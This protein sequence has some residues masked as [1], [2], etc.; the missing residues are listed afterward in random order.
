MRTAQPDERDFEIDCTLRANPAVDVKSVLWVIGN[1]GINLTVGESKEGYTANATVSINTKKALYCQPV[2]GG[3]EFIHFISYIS[4]HQ[5]SNLPLIS[6]LLIRPTFH[7]YINPNHLYNLPSPISI[8]I[9]YTTFH[10]YI[11]PNHSP[12]LSPLYQSQPFIQP[13]T[14]YQSQPFIQP[15][16]PISIPTFHP[17]LHPYINPNDSSNLSPHINHNHSSNLPPYINHNH[18]SI[19]P[20]YINPSN[21]LNRPPYINPKYPFNPTLCQSQTF[22]QPST[23]Y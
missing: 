7:P 17:T 22:I 12:N 23:P 19:H 13:S 11:N 20:P 5:S 16:T 18:S 4:H 3:C 1:T 8:P 15:F 21:S 14:L 10:P 2:L 9:I 6:I